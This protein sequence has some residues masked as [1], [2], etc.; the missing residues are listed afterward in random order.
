[1]HVEIITL[2]VFPTLLNTKIESGRCYVFFEIICTIIYFKKFVTPDFFLY[3]KWLNVKFEKEVTF[4]KVYF[5]LSN[6]KGGN[7]Y[8]A[9]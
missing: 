7:Y 6:L 4:Y 3:T 1:V 8:I 2:Q 5:K 9:G